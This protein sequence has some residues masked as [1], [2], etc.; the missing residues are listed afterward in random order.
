MPETRRPHRLHEGRKGFSEV[1]EPRTAAEKDLEMLDKHRT[2][3][4]VLLQNG[5]FFPTYIS[6]VTFALR[7]YF[8]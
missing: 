1:F 5:S 4:R 6:F 8:D 3:Q 7:I 2:A